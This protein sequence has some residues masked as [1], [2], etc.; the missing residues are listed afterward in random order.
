M[1]PASPIVEFAAKFPAAAKPRAALQAALD[2]APLP[3]IVRSR[4]LMEASRAEPAEIRAAVRHQSAPIGGW[5]VWPTGAVSGAD[6]GYASAPLPRAMLRAGPAR[7]PGPPHGRLGIRP[8]LCLCARRN[9]LDWAAPFTEAEVAAAIGSVLPAALIRDPGQGDGPSCTGLVYGEPTPGMPAPGIAEISIS[10]WRG[11]KRNRLAECVPIPDFVAPLTWLAN[12]GL[13]RH[14][15]AN[16]GGLLAGQMVVFDLSADEIRIDAGI[17]TRLAI[18]G[19]GIV[20]FCL[21][22]GE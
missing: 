14:G 9:L 4:P 8:A 2:Q 21:E 3:W 22:P 17:W 5:R 7:I 19:F 12:D 11:W 13:A 10:A 1:T 15:S 20:E 16:G 18:G 6:S